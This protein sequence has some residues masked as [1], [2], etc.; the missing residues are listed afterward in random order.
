MKSKLETLGRQAK[1]LL[2]RSQSNSR[3]GPSSQQG[4]STNL[5]V[6]FAALGHSSHSAGSNPRNNASGGLDGTNQ[7]TDDEG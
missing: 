2:K 4:I 1:D 5:P 6:R 7:D 3:L